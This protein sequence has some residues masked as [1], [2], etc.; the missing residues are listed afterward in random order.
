MENS[1]IKNVVFAIHGVNSNQKKNWTHRFEKQFRQDANFKE[2]AF[3]RG[4][5]GYLFFIFSFLPFIRYFKIK[6]V[7]KRLRDVQKKYSNA[8][9][10]VIAHSYG[11]MLTYQATQQSDLNF[12]EIPIKIGKFILIAGIVSHYE[13]FKDTLQ[14]GQ[15]QSIHNFC[16]Y[17]DWIVYHQPS[18][19]KCGYYGFVKN[20]KR[21]HK[22]KPYN[23][24]Q[25]YN[26]RFKVTH[27]Q[28]FTIDTLNFYILWSQI[29]RKK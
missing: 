7:Q 9:I 12:D 29:L 15:I 25:I 18:F 21:E 20:R 24:L 28:Y 3:E 11:T 22:F 10:H 8:T 1:H 4:N 27:G 17:K 26:Y 6:K 2:W 14:D 23:D 16:S 5:W 19:G 13:R